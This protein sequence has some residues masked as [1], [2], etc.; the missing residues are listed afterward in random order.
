MF[1]REVE[2]KKL[3]SAALAH[4]PHPLLQA[5]IGRGGAPGAPSLGRGGGR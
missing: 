2:Q 1:V 5:D 4:W 3:A